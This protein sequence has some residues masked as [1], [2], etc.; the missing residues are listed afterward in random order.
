MRTSEIITFCYLR[1]QRIK[2][3]G[4]CLGG[5][6][7]GHQLPLANGVHDFYADDRTPSCPKRLEPEHRTSEPFHC[8]MILFYDIIEILGVTDEDGGLVNLIVVRNGCRIRATLID[9]N[10]L[11]ESLRA[12]GLA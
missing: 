6:P 7:W 11:W 12:N 1:S 2:L 8:A 4:G 5:V 10:F 9:G 3:L